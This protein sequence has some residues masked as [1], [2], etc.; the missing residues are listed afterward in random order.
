MAA[1]LIAVWVIASLP[2]GILI[3]RGIFLG[4]RDAR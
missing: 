1:Y 4:S 3:G 2:I